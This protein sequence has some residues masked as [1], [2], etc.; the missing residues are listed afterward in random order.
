MTPPTSG[1]PLVAVIGDAIRSRMHA[2]RPAL[3]AALEIALKETNRLVPAVHGL[4]ITL[5]DEF[6]GVY[7]TIQQAVDAT[8][9]V[10]LELM[11]ETS[12]RFGIGK[13][14]VLF[15]DE[16]RWPFGQDGPLWWRAREALE[17][18]VAGETANT[19]PRS[20]RT[21]FRGD[22]PGDAT[23][24]SL[25][26]LRDQIVSGLDAIDGAILQKLLGGET[27]ATIAAELD[28]HPSSVSRRVQRHGLAALLAARH[29]EPEAAHP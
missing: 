17:A 2:D 18:V 29:F 23:C 4:T 21:A 24:N 27:Q 28:L 5:G 20:R 19:T 26:T 14:E 7:E 3:Q 22:G 15:V 16:S 10:Q 1:G 11:G 25:L 13:G 9:V 6:Q 8:L 12:V